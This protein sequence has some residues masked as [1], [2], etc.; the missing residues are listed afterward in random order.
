MID[1]VHKE[2]IQKVIDLLKVDSN[3]LENSIIKKYYFGVPLK[4]LDYPSI[5]VQLNERRETGRN[6]L[7]QVLYDY[8]IEVGVIDRAINEDDA[9]K[10][11]YDKLELVEAILDDNPTLAGL[12]DDIKPAKGIEI[13]HASESDYAISIGRLLFSARKV[14]DHD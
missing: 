1:L 5:W 9:E 7:N 10:S 8:V 13:I 6:A 12:V 4:F 14:L 3:L 2:I 11:V